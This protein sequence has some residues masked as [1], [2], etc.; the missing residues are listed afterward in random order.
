[1][2]RWSVP[3]NPFDSGRL[4]HALYNEQ[5]DDERLTLGAVEGPSPLLL[6]V[7]KCLDAQDAD[8]ESTTA[9]VFE[10]WRADPLAG[11]PAVARGGGILVREFATLEAAVDALSTLGAE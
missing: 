6:V 2:I 5:V 4:A 10:V 8:G 11:A 9:E 1:M 3:W 7:R